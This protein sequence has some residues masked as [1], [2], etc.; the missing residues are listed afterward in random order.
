VILDLQSPVVTI[1]I[2]GFNIKKFYVLFTQCVHVFCT[3][4]RTNNKF[5]PL[6]HQPFGFYNE[7]G[8]CLLRSKNRVFKS[9]L[10]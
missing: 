10:G 3:D 5:F 8:A 4:F 2:I 9:N 7:D 1:C 6:R